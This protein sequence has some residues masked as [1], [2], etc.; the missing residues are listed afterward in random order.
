MVILTIQHKRSDDIV[1]KMIAVQIEEKPT[2]FNYTI[3]EPL[4]IKAN[5][6]DGVSLNLNPKYGVVLRMSKG[7]KQ[8]FTNNRITS[9]TRT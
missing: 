1:N 6:T 8:G 9:S 4:L 3:R 7:V 5:S 2:L